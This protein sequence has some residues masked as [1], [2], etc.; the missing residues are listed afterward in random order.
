MV[1][2]KF[3]L[4]RGVDALFSKIDSSFFAKL[5]IEKITP[6]PFQPRTNFNQSE[7][8]ELAKYLKDGSTTK[9]C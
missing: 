6:N 5:N 9:F 8:K 7:L 3:G 2:K 4:G 1:N